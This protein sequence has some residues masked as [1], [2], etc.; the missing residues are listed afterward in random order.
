MSVAD[1]RHPRAPRPAPRLPRPSAHLGTA[2]VVQRGRAVRHA[3]IAVATIMAA[4]TLVPTAAAAQRPTTPPYRDPSRSVAERVRDLVGRM[5]LEE[6]FRQLFMIPGD[7]DDPSHDYSTGIFGLQVSVTK[8]GDSSAIAGLA[9]GA[10]ARAHA[11]RIN[12]IQRHFVE[13]TRLGIP[14]L[15][16]DEALHGLMREGAT[17]FPQAIALAATWD[18]GLVARVAAAT[19]REAGSRGVRQVLSPVVNVARDARWGRVEESY[20]EDPYLTSMMGRAFIAAFEHR[21]IVATP[22]HFVANV[23]EGGRDSY[24]VDLGERAL[25]EVHFPPFRDAIRQA[26]ARSV[27]TAYN[28]VD[29]LPATQNRRLLAETLKHRWG[30]EGFVISDAAATGGATVLHMTEPDT[31]T[32]AQHAFESGLDVIFQSSFPQHLPYWEAF[33]RGLIADSLIDASVSRVL[34][35]KFEL[36]IFERPYADPDSA[37]HWNGHPAHR[38]LAREAARQAL[39]LLRNERRLLPLADS[40]RRIAVIGADAAE[41][42]LGGYSG[43]GNGP[44]TILDGVRARAGGRSVVRY[45]RGAGRVAPTHVVVP[46]ASLRHADGGRQVQGLRGEYFDNPALEG[47]P[48]AVRSDEQVDF[49]WTF[50]PP[51][52]GLATDWYGVRWRGELVAPPAGVRRL[53]VDG[54]D[55]WRLWLDDSLVIDNWRKQSHRALLAD[56][57]L[58]PGSRHDIR[59]EYRETTGNARVRLVWDAG[60]D[61]DWR[62]SVD[63]AA[64]IARASD[65]AIVVAGIEEGEFRDRASLALPGHQE[66]LIEAVAATGTPTVVVLVGG[67]AITM[68]RWLGRVDA[69]LMAWYPGEAGGEA[70]A[71]VLFG[72]HAPGGRLPIT[73]PIAEGQL[74]LYLGHAPTGRGDDYLDLTGKPRF[75]FGFGLSYTDFA[76]ERLAIEPATIVAGATVRVR[77]VVRNVG[78][79]AGDEVVQLYLRDELATVARPVM[80]LA[81]FRR[82]HLAPGEAR[83]VTFALDAG[84]LSLLDRS[85]RR[86]VEPGTFR[87]MVGASSADIRLRGHLVVR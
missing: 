21:G 29:G 74:P 27:M 33:R 37:A 31:P 17:V 30:F 67:S 22:K 77:C 61:A 13:R 12:D 72:D 70:V 50:A 53:G 36:G 63:S 78:T 83:E 44:V 65:V 84:Q 87:I 3:A 79:R 19:A 24:P 57:A 42:R 8:A 56:V 43:P 35:A 58:R 34:R 5:T 7:L 62:P 80:Q 71:D 48:R 9:P 73:F 10:V 85:L 39:V 11:Q 4:G 52:P 64:A 68:E 15:P 20:G 41:A 59:L 51:A 23:G 60:A 49:G 86:V 26:G 16:F 55:G 75:P 38:A 45:V 2:S 81:G 28:S 18:S 1:S 69:V 46:A 25:E 66:A 47:A 6:K 40:A 32:A 76:Y 54:S 14:M 82:L